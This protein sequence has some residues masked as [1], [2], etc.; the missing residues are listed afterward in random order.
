MGTERQMRQRNSEVVPATDYETYVLTAM[1]AELR[2]EYGKRCL[3]YGV[4]PWD[5]SV[6]P[7]VRVAGTPVNAPEGFWDTHINYAEMWRNDGYV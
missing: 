6:I 4:E 3:E 2:E 1:M 7:Y 5:F